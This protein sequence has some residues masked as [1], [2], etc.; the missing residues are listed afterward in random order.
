MESCSGL[1]RSEREAPKTLGSEGEERCCGDLG[2]PRWRKAGK[3]S[4]HCGGRGC[5]VEAASRLG[6]NFLEIIIIK[7]RRSLY[8]GEK[9]RF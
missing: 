7:T 2:L 1:Q 8:L 9:K 3:L 4:A 5:N 6:V